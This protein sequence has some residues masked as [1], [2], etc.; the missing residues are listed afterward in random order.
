MQAHHQGCRPGRGRCPG[1]ELDGVYLHGHEGYLLDQLTNP[2]FNRRMLGHYSDWQTFGLDLVREIRDRVGPDYPIMYRIDLTL[3]LHE[4]YGE[5]MATGRFAEEIPS[6][7]QRGE[8]L[9]FMANLVKAGVDMFD[10][11]LG[12]YDNWWLPHPP[13]FMPSG[14][15]LPVSRLVKQFLAENKILSNAGLPVPVVAVGKLGYPDL[16]E[17][18]LRDGDLRPDHARPSAAGRPRTGRARPTPGGSRDLSLHRRPG[19]LPER[20]LSKAVTSS[21][22]STRAPVSKM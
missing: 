19:S 13:T 3:A 12:C 8:T 21:A 10:V 22:R 16:A 9:E 6:R 5:R 2:A 7:A 11:D 20:D 17:N 14:V 18:A 1:H 4:T 15:F